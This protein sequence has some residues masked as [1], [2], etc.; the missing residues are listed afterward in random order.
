MEE[1]AEFKEMQVVLAANLQ[2][3]RAAK[4][5]SQEKLALD[6]NVHRTYVSQL[7]RKLKNPS[8]LILSRLAKV[9]E[10]DVVA[11]LQGPDKVLPG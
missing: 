10:S 8:L 9:L 1:D 11:L 7:E 4:K 3:L 2:R 6:A 5:I